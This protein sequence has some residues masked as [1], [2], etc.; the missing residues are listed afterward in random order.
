MSHQLEVIVASNLYS[1][2]YIPKDDYIRYLKD[3]ATLI[4][5]RIARLNMVGNDNMKD[6]T[7]DTTFIDS[8][9]IR[10]TSS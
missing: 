4:I 5:N 8:E 6:D 2:G 9:L 7:V 3:K 1:Q 10:V